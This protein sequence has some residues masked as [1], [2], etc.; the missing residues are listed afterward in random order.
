M[1]GGEGEVGLGERYEDRMF[2][3]GDPYAEGDVEVGWEGGVMARERGY[4]G[5]HASVAER[6]DGEKGGMDGRS[7]RAELWEMKRNCTLYL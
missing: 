2:G 5:G 4:G 3:D 1:M 7:E 6:E